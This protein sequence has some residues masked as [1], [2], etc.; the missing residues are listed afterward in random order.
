MFVLQMTDNCYRQTT[1]EELT[2]MINMP[3]PDKGV[4]DKSIYTKNKVKIGLLYR[5]AGR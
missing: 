3:P 2:C 1:K 5:L 4:G